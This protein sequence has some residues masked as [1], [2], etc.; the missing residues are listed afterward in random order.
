MKIRL[1]KKKIRVANSYIISSISITFVLL[2]LGFFA[3]FLFNV[4]DLSINAKENVAVTIILKPDAQTG[5]ID[6][7]KNSIASQNYCKS[8]SVVTPD[9]ALQNIKDE[10]GE[11]IGDVLDY[12]PLPA[13]ISLTLN[14]DYANTDSLQ[15][16]ETKFKLSD[17]VDDVFYNKSMIYQLDK[18]VRKIGFAVLI[19]EILLLLMA[20][21]LISNTIRLQIHSKRFEIN[22]M[23]LVGATS[24]FI[25]KPFI[26]NSLWHGLFSSLIAIASLLI[27]IIYYQNNVDDIVKIG[28]LV[29]VFGI[30]LFTGIVITFL[31]TFLSVS[32]YLHSK[33]E[34]LYIN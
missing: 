34:D 20:T 16:I 17:I 10:L 19:L 11:D 23:Q 3:L 31:S 26:I 32:K 25:M 21:S 14:A 15:I 6:V 2:V 33:T 5:D 30:V 29:E 13:T 7:L 1:L 27:G 22:T 24:G 18:N 28:H 4:K 12:N 8:I 9:E